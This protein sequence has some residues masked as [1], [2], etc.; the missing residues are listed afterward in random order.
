MCT[1]VQSHCYPSQ[2]QWISFESDEGF[3]R[4]VSQLIS[5]LGSNSV[6]PSGAGVDKQEE[7]EYHRAI[8]ST[9]SKA[10]TVRMCNTYHDTGTIVNGRPCSHT[11]QYKYAQ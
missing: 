11:F 10:L 5:A 6:S 7:V 2:L 3:D 4:S 8:H 9:S 1:C